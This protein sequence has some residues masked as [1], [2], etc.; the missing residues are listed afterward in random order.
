M[1]A[2]KKTSRQKK[3]EV[4]LTFLRQTKSGKYTKIDKVQISNPRVEEQSEELDNEK[5]YY[6]SVR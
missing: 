1:E 5:V 2:K 4:L 3:E 6:Y